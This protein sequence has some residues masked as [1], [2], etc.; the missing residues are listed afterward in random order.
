[1]TQHYARMNTS[2]MK[3][4]MV[5]LDKV[6]NGGKNAD[7]ERMKSLTTVFDLN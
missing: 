2:R 4:E 3:A 1:M 6:L 7:A 5:K